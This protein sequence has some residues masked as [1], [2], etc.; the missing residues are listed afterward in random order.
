MSLWLVLIGFAIG[1][2]PTASTPART[3]RALGAPAQD[4]DRARTEAQARRVDDR[5]RALQGEA[6]RL[7]GE[8]R[9]L[10]GELR[11]LEIEQ[12]L[13]IER[14]SEAQAAVER[15]RAAVDEADARL[16]ALE[17][18][19]LA[20][21]PD[22]KAQ[23]VDIYKRGRT[24][25]TKLLFGTTSVREFGRALRAVAALMRIN[26]GRV[27]EHRR[28]LDELRRERAAIEEEL[29]ALEAHDADA[30]RARAA[31]DRA[32][33]A[34]ARLLAQID[35]RR[36]LTAQLAGELQLAHDRLQQQLA[37]LAG[38]RAV[39]PVAV[40]VAP[41]RGAL[42]WPVPG[43]VLVPFGKAPGRPGDNS[44]RNGIEIAAPAGTPVH[45]VHPGTVSYAEPFTGF[46]N[47]VIVDH[48]ANAYT[49]YGYLD[50]VAV[51]RGTPVDAGTELG[52]VGSAPA[53]PPALYFEVRVDG[54]SVDPIQWLRPN[55]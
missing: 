35:S 8:A 6:D 9:T 14:V 42:E 7:A 16:E 36:D 23:L 55:R 47:L 33:A 52:R 26:E 21:L 30:R 10:L 2:A 53:G 37:A 46:G 39:E 15:G 3:L 11:T 22:L 40:P 44:A 48:G 49:V 41:F 45:A 24:G 50:T 28:T 27:A 19:R 12:Q 51:P 29:R 13:Q 4:A 5:I 34:R 32:L 43:R 38:G 25:Y 54:R 18:Q 1:A 17:Q 31:A 20:Q